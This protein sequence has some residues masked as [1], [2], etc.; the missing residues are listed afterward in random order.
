MKKVISLLLVLVMLCSSFAGLQITSHAADLPS[1]GSC[2]E[3][4][5][6]TFDSATGLLT[7]SGSGAMRAS[8]F[9]DYADIKTV[10]INN[11]VT[12]IGYC[13]FEYCSGLTSI[14]IPDSVTSIG[15][16]AFSGCSGLTSITIPD[17][18][19]SIGRSAFFGCSGLTSI[20]IPD[21]V[22]RIRDSA[23]FR[24]SGLTIVSI[25]NSVT[26]I[27]YGAFYGCSGLT[28]ITIP[29]SVKSIGSSA[30]DGCGGLTSLTI[31]N[32][33]TSIGSYAFRGCSGLTS[34]S[35]GNSV[36][37]I[38]FAAF[39][40]F[41]SLKDVY[42]SGSESEWNEIDI[43]DDNEYL[44]AA[45]L[46]LNTQPVHT[47]EY[48]GAITT[49]ATCIELGVMTYTCI[50]GE[51]YTDVIPATGH[52]SIV[53]N[54]VEPTCTKTGL[55]EGEKCSVCDEIIKA[56]SI[57]DAL[58]HAFGAWQQTKA[59][60]CTAKGE[61]TRVCTRDASHKETRTVE[62]LGHDFSAAKVILATAV[63]VGYTEHTCSRCGELQKVD[64]YTAPTGKLTLKH[65]ARTANA[66]K[67]QWNNVKSATGYQV[68]I[69]TK[70]GKKWDKT[71]TLKAGVTSY[72]FKK[73]AAGNNYKF[74]VRFYIKA[75]DGK[76]Y[77]SPWSATL[78]SP[79]LPVGTTLTK[80]TPAKKAFTARWK[81]Q[82]VSGY[83]VQ[84]SLKAN[85]AG[86]KTITVKNPKS[87]KATASK[88]YAG[89]Y[90]YVRI[91]TYKTIA[92]ANYFSAWSK[93]YKVKTK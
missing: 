20:T 81:K 85:F 13:A 17:S 1:S 61:E 69:S 80:L 15:E 56:Q 91:R 40:G 2:G 47:H 33:V 31:P 11:G 30:F 60:T 53:L 84:Y 44:L 62:A 12:Y 3:N 87:L 4:V 51:K 82:A 32:S 22:T 10:V 64:T 46:H 38:D 77:F 43:G 65:S 35:I 86:A 67:V 37:S 16:S 39:E 63:S 76:N 21:S 50:C 74:R 25:G 70:D 55:T 8:A 6:Y 75:D 48:V 93:T 24:C 27:G 92:K 90:Y 66:I 57:I 28:S 23:F 26:S 5:T 58:E 54:A 71:V 19:T 72:T 14:T 68:Q 79:T 78:N 52:K 29:D 7:I 45:N 9:K 49:P 83:Q 18:V 36:T 34:V 42:Y 59:P 73:L 41:Y 89:K 88:L